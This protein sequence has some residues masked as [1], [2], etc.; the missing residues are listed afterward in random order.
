MVPSHTLNE[1][2]L[3]VRFAEAL[4]YALVV[5]GG[6]L[7]KGTTIPYAGHLLGVTSLVIDHGGTETEAMA[8]LLHDAP[9]DCGG[10]R[11]LDDIAARFG[12]VVAG[13]VAG[14]SDSLVEDP[15]R[16]PPWRERKERYIAHL[17]GS[18]DPA[19]FLVSAADKLHNARAILSDYI[20]LGEALWGRFNAGRLDLLWYYN[21]MIAAYCKGPQDKRRDDMTRILK[22]TVLELEDRI[23]G[24]VV[25]GAPL[26]SSS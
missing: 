20:A 17:R 15:A 10:Q 11:R 23:R 19:V 13:I 24:A 7:R 12:P 5:H 16:K 6:Q 1:Q 14:C 25:R 22:G 9:E 8:A 21:E 3:T 26:V 18:D 2:A 4:S